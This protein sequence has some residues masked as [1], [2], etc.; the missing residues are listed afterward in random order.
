MIVFLISMEVRF[1]DIGQLRH[2]DQ[3]WWRGPYVI[4]C[5][6]LGHVFWIVLFYRSVPQI[7]YD[8]YMIWIGFQHDDCICVFNYFVILLLLSL[9]AS[10]LWAKAN[11]CLQVVKASKSWN[12][13]RGNSKY[14]KYIQL[15]LCV[16]ITKGGQEEHTNFT[17][18][19]TQMLTGCQGT[20]SL[21]PTIPLC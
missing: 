14:T 12:M 3:R 16:C 2:E 17:T 7:H 5:Y 4:L 21:H 6:V 20:M 10:K 1:R 19:R 9:W 8:F 13:T 15:Q 11:N 18:Q